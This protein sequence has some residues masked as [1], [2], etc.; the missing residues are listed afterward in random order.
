MNF[1]GHAWVAGW[2]SEREPFILG[3]MLPDFASMLRVAAPVSRTVELSAGIRLHHRTDVVFHQATAFCTLE[4]EARRALEVAGVTKGARRA[5]AHVGVEFLIDE[6]LGERAPGWAGYVRALHFG[7]SEACSSAL[8]WTLA[9]SGERFGALCRRLV[10]AAN[11][12]AGD[13][14]LAARLVASL[15]GRPRLELSAAEAELLV[16]WLAECR[17]R[18]ASLMPELLAELARELDAPAT[19]LRGLA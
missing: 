8:D 6:Q 15:A 9:G 10:G 12:S 11:R 14:V 19:R 16:P 18:V 5:L 3:S 4:R 7:G 1:Y 2:F 17:P 13:E